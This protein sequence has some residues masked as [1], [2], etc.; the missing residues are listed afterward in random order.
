VKKLVR[1]RIDP[2]VGSLE[3]SGASEPARTVV[4]QSREQTC[5]EGYTWDLSSLVELGECQCRG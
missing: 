1:R 4:D 2:S 5:E 3:G